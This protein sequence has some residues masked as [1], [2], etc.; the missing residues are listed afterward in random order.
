MS[1]YVAM[2]ILLRPLAA[3]LYPIDNISAAITLI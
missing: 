1:D 2:L 3:D